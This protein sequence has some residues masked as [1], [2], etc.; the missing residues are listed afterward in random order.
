MLNN[1]KYL[2]L[3]ICVALLCFIG[4]GAF[5][6]I[7]FLGNPMRA[8]EIYLNA[9]ND[10][11]NENYSNAYY[12]FSKVSYLSNLKPYA[13]FHKV[14][15]ANALNDKKAAERQNYLLFNIYPKNELSARAKYFYAVDITQTEPKTAQKYFED[16]IKKYPATDYSTGAKYR[17]AAILDKKFSQDELSSSIYKSEYENYLREY[18]REAPTGKWALP[19]IDMWLKNSDNMT[20]EDKI[21]VSDILCLYNQSERAEK[22]LLTGNFD[23]TWAKRAK[24]QLLRGKKSQ[25]FETITDGLKL[26][27]SSVPENEKNEVLIKYILSQKNRTNAISELAKAAQGKNDLFIKTQKCKYTENH[28]SRAQCFANIMKFYDYRTFTEPVLFEQFKENALSHNYD[29]ARNL[30]SEFLNKYPFSLNSDA[31]M[32]WLGKIALRTGKDA[33]AR[34]YFQKIIL[35]Y[36]DSYYAMRSYVTANNI[37]N[38][39]ITRQIEPESILFPYYNKANTALIKLA[40]FKDYS[41]LSAVYERDLFVQSWILYEKNEPSK[42]MVLARDAMAQLE[43]KPDK[44][45]LRWRLVYPTFLYNDIKTFAQ[46]AGNNPVLMLAL[47]REE[48]YFNENAHSYVGAKGLMQ[49]MPDTAREINKIKSLGINNYDELYTKENNL[50]LG[51]MY[52][53]FLLNNLNHNNILA[54]AAYNGGIGSISRWK[55]GVTYADIDEFVE[56]IPYPETR[57]YVK[58]VFRT[59]WN[60]ARIYL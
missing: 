42:A 47:I 8:D 41:A 36:P 57:N 3:G 40:E 9:L 11:K 32:Y 5:L 34:D 24:T 15:C 44:S 2:I 18:L 58:K 46:D 48:S 20:D 53:N 45:D 25:A 7:K 10:L 6:F 27:N 1:K 49:L 52:Y 16:I 12:Q 26:K 31:V 28:N 39:I 56:K 19:A 29:I 17:I 30:G 35:T 22:L 43:Q 50:M 60:Y 37:N 21:L 54:I 55:T 51:N 33:E 23:R 13:I 4:I 14:E 38:S 59:Y